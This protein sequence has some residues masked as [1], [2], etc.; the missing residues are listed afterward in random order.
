MGKKQATNNASVPKIQSSTSTV[1][2]RSDFVAHA[3]MKLN[4]EQ[5]QKRQHQRNRWFRFGFKRAALI[6][7][8]PSIGRVGSG[9]FWFLLLF[10]SANRTVLA[11]TLKNWIECKW[12]K[13]NKNTTEWRKIC[14]KLKFINEKTENEWKIMLFCLCNFGQPMAIRWQMNW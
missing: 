7:I 12:K 6:L 5:Q 4:A 3:Q 13:W 9:L 14:I 11:S 8:W 10:V 1:E 2:C